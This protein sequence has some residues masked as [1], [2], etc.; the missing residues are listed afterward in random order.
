MA[1]TATDQI[2]PLMQTLLEAGKQALI[3]A[4]RPVTLASLAPGAT[5]A[6]DNCEDNGIS[7]GQL[8]VRIVTAFPTMGQSSRGGRNSP[9]PAA[10][11]EQLCG[12]NFLAVQFGLGVVRCVATVNDDGVTPSGDQM[13]ADALGMTQDAAA[14]LRA[15][16]CL[17]PAQRGAKNVL[18]WTPQG[19]Q[20]GCAGGEWTFYMPVPVCGCQ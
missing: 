10:D 15:I 2:G 7:E 13:T 8:W 16:E 17:V 3:D 18:S 11:T 1:D 5:V 4:G 14:L 9:F 20:G 19:P 6:W 12:I